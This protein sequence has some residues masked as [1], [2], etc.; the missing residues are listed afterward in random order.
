MVPFKGP[1]L[2]VS[3]LSFVS[4]PFIFFFR[5]PSLSQ[6]GGPNRPP[7]SFCFLLPYFLKKS[8]SSL[9]L[10]CLTFFFKVRQRRLTLKK[11]VDKAT[12]MGKENKKVRGNQTV[13]Y[14]WIKKNKESNIKYNLFCKMI[15]CIFFYIIMNE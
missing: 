13:I 10:L 7:L 9:S 3:P 8:N 5:P 14:K 11:K 6:R 15:F 12:K 4:S 2:K 1:D